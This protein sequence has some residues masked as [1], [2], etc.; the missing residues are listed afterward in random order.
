MARTCLD[1][2]QFSC[3]NSDDPN[4]KKLHALPVSDAGYKAMAK[5]ADQALAVWNDGVDLVAGSTH[6]LNPQVAAPSWARGKVPAVTITH[7]AF[8]AGIA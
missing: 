7:H 4:A 1:P 8:Y 6:Y 3:W 2:E 5:A